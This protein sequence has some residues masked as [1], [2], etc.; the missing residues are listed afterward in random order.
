MCNRNGNAVGIVSAFG[1]QREFTESDIKV[2]QTIGQMAATEFELREKEEAEKRIRE[3]LL[4]SQK[5]EA[6]GTLA[7]E[8]HM[9][10]TICFRESSD[11]HRC[12]S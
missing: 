11:M 12:S 9:T 8:S 10:L 6:V 4:Q 3:E 5:L 2:F 1:K 7:G